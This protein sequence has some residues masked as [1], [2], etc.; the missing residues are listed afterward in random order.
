MHHE[1]LRRFLL[2]LQH[3]QDNGGLQ[4]F[5]DGD[6]ETWWP[7]LGFFITDQPENDLGTLISGCPICVAPCE[8]FDDT[9]ADFEGNA[10]RTCW[11]RP[12]FVRV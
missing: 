9:F 2:E 4:T 12:D 8:N 11:H 6:V 10:E 7:V 5:H 3:L 1:Q